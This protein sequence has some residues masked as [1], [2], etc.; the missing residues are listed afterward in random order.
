MDVSPEE[1]YRA[2]ELAA[3]NA[4]CLRRWRQRF[5]SPVLLIWPDACTPTHRFLVDRYYAQRVFLA[6]AWMARS[7]FARRQ[8]G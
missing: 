4:V 1:A 3:R 8:V 7:I 5:H 6:R 2:L